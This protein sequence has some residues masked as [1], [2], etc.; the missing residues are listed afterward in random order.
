MRVPPMLLQPLV[1]NAI[2]HG[3]EPRVEGGEVRVSARR[4]G[5]QVVLEVRDTG[6]GFAPTTRGGTGLTNIRDRLRLLYAGK[7]ALDITENPP[8]APWSSIRI[9]GM[10]PRALIADDEPHLAQHL[11]ARLGALWPELALLPLAANGLEACARSTTRRPTWPSSTSACRGSPASTSRAASTAARTSS[12]SPPTTSTPS[13]PSSA[14]R[15]T[16]C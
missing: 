14:T 4:E 13:R 11:A 8:A 9:P 16:T 5:P 12:S 6:V 10:S 15:W 3:L 1:E 7:A 2:R